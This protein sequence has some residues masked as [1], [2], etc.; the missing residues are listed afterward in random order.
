MAARMD[1][2]K[3]SCCVESHL[4]AG[5]C[6][7]LVAAMP[8]QAQQ[9]QLEE[10][11]FNMLVIE[12]GVELRNDQAVAIAVVAVQGGATDNEAIHVGS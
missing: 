3:T 1:T 4:L 7:G 12:T 6:L 9:L 5:L 8:A 10:P 11:A 2:I